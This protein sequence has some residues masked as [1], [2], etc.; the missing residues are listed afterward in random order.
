MHEEGFKK[1]LTNV[2]NRYARAKGLLKEK[3]DNLL[4]EDIREGLTAIV[5]VKL[6]EPQFEGQTKAKLGNVSIRSLVERVAN[7][8]FAD[9]LEENPTEARQ[10]VAK[11][12]QA[13]RARMAARQA[14]EL[15][16]RKTLL[17]GAG[18]PGKL[19]DCSSRD[20]EESELFIVEGN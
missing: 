15:T 13:A 1:A 4:G 3:D 16:R 17:E 10:I 11:G 19:A 18:L 8:K 14:R 9:W 7:E 12:T 6:R 20:P 2:V 5:S